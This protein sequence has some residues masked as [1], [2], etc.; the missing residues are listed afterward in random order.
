MDTNV[1]STLL[2]RLRVRAFW[3][4]VSR[5]CISVGR[6]VT[7]STV[8]GAL[9][10]AAP[11]KP[12]RAQNLDDAVAKQLGFGPALTTP[13]FDLL[14]GATI[15]PEDV[16]VGPLLVICK[17]LAPLP[18]AGPSSAGGGGATT[19]QTLPRIVQ[20][21]QREFRSN[22]E[23][24]LPP[25][26]DGASA[27]AVA[28]YLS[29]L[30]VFLAAKYGW[31]D[32]DRTEFEDGYDSDYYRIT[33]GADYE[34]TEKMMAGIALEYYHRDGEFRNGGEFDND[35]Y[36]ILGFMS[37][38][39]ASN[40]FIDVF[41]RLVKNNYDRTRMASL[42]DTRVTTGET[43]P[44]AGGLLDGS[45]D[46]NAYEAGL[47]AGYDHAIRE[48][49]IGPHVG[50]KWN[51]MEFDGYSEK[52]TTGL[53]LRFNDDHETLLQSTVGVHAL[54]V[55]RNDHGVFLPRI[56]LDWKHEFKNDQRDV[57]VSFVGDR[58]SKLFVYETEPPDRDFFE[59]NI[60]IAAAL[61]NGIQPYLNYQ[62]LFGHRFF[63]GHAVSVGLRVPF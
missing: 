23:E 39:P 60:G 5:Q 16:L 42:I 17:R 48:S 9:G 28:E 56:G 40:A 49:I 10:I 3:K 51:R 24:N 63:D 11:E 43:I 57:E 14:D 25:L 30:G 41:G 20:Q 27:D 53:E 32:R 45:Y 46:G 26:A 61:S 29:G 21:R 4:Q 54:T 34:F 58:R 15:V 47:F 22:S 31:L 38:L 59:V 18:G 7:V 37:M 2:G 6:V 62:G 33:A 44:V 50:L 1:E 36:G 12:L 52:G 13:C 35:S 55:F 8:L 19:P